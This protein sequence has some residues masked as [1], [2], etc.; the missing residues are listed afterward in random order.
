MAE[1]TPTEPS[2]LPTVRT[3]F[4]LQGSTTSRAGYATSRLSLRVVDL[5]TVNPCGQQPFVTSVSKRHLLKPGDDQTTGQVLAARCPP[6]RPHC[7]EAR[8]RAS[9]ARQRQAVENTR[10]PPA[11]PGPA[12]CLCGTTG[13]TCT[14]LLQR[15]TST[16]FKDMIESS[17]QESALGSCVFGD[18]LQWHSGAGTLRGPC[19]CGRAPRHGLSVQVDGS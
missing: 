12:R 10:T 19:P 13:L 18:V 9:L 14:H 17:R 4:P 5:A 16:K 8:T 15:A 3:A 11:A 1:H 6:H 2:L 7:A